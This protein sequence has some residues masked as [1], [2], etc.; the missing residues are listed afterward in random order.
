LTSEE[1]VPRN[2]CILHR[3]VIDTKLTANEKRIDGL[4][5]K[6]DEV[7]NMQRNTLI[8]IVSILI[9]LILILIGVLIGRGVDFGMFLGAV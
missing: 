6:I 2:E 7:L 4:E 9:V 5:T 1:Y 8:S 3:Q